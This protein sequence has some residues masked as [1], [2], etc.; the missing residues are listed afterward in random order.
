ME[1][2]AAKG[3]DWSTSSTQSPVFTTKF[4]GT[5]RVEKLLL[6]YKVDYKQKKI[7]VKGSRFVGVDEFSI[8][9]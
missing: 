9:S 7:M 1:G 2:T 6:Q 3:N 8:Y 4:P 5:E